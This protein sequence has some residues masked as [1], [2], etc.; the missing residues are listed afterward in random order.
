MGSWE[1]I[2]KI[3]G[4]TLALTLILR[5]SF[6]FIFLVASRPAAWIGFMAAFGALHML[7]AFWLDFNPRLVATA[8]ILAIVFALPSKPKGAS[9][10]EA[11]ELRESLYQG[12]GVSRGG[13]KRVIGHV[14][15]AGVS[16]A[17]Y[18]LAFGEVC[19]PAG[20]CTPIYRGLFSQ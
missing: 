17:I 10:Q 5:W 4:Y 9:G 7:A 3:A 19:T 20:A 6:F 1:L 11:K 12:A 14:A 13:L 18:V 15:F 16:V 2:F 8:T